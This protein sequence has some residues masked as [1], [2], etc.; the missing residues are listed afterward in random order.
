MCTDTAA[1]E[2]ETKSDP[3]QARNSSAEG[4]LEPELFCDSDVH[5]VGEAGVVEFQQTASRT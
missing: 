1:F 5:C 3:A 2:Q 4:K